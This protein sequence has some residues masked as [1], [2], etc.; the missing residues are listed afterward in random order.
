MDNK[1]IVILK[2][3]KIKNKLRMRFYSYLKNDEILKNTYNNSYNMRFPKNIRKEN[4]FYSVP[5]E[6]IKFARGKNNGKPFY[7]VNKKN[8]KI[9]ENYD[10]EYDIKKNLKIYKIVDSCIICLDDENIV[11]QIFAPCGHQI[12]CYDCLNNLKN[13]NYNSPIKCPLCKTYINDILVDN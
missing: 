9:C 10:E 2:C 1:D 4:L 13:N 5:K 7:I 6:D 11:D 12:C 3:V 8:I